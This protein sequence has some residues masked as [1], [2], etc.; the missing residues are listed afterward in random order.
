MVSITD[1]E[2]LSLV[3]G[4]TNESQHTP[5]AFECYLDIASLANRFCMVEIEEWARKQLAQVLCSSWQLSYLRWNP[6]SLLEGLWYSKLTHDREFEHN[7]RNLIECYVD[8]SPL[9][10][11][12]DSSRASSIAQFYTD[13]ML[14]KQDAALFGHIFCAVLS[15]GHQSSFWKKLDSRRQISPF[16]G[17]SLPHAASDQS[18]YRLD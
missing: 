7:V 18:A 16:C 12:F 11:L 13:S 15:V 4:A 6:T 1:P 9:S 2:Y 5:A 17:P 14:K 3:S 8:F 10:S